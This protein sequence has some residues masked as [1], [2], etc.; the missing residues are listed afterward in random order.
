M[1]Y[2]MVYLIAY[3]LNH[4]K[5]EFR[6]LCVWIRNNKELHSR[7]L[8]DSYKLKYEILQKKA[9]KR[10][11]DILSTYEYECNM[12]TKYLVF[13]KL[14]YVIPDIIDIVHLLNVDTQKF[15]LERIV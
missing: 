14:F 3:R 6:N 12:W 8:A 2:L 13:T 11:I 7:Y 1:V 4:Q 5:T 9:T 15:W 10:Y